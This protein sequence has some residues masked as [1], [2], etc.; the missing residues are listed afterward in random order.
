MGFAS[1]RGAMLPAIDN[2]RP[3][4]Q[5]SSGLKVA[6]AAMLGVGAFG[7]SMPAN[8]YQAS[9]DNMRLS[10]SSLGKTVD[11]DLANADLSLVVDAI[12]RQT[13]ANIVIRSGDHPFGKV[14]VH[15]SNM[16]I[17]RALQ[18]VALSAGASLVKDADGTYILKQGDDSETVAQNQVQ[19]PSALT[20]RSYREADLHWYKMVLQHAVPH[21][22][23]Y[24]L[25][26]DEGVRDIDPFA[27]RLDRSD[28]FPRFDHNPSIVLATGENVPSVPAGLGSMGPAQANRTQDGD[29][30]QQARQFPG[31]FGGG[32]FGGGG[33]GGG[34]GGIGGGIGGVGGGIGGAGGIGGQQQLPEGVDEIIALQADNSLLVKATPEAFQKMREIIK[35]I[36]VAPRQVQIRVE[37]VRADVNDVDA[38]GINYEFVPF[39]GINFASDLGQGGGSYG[40]NFATGNLVGQ[41]LATLT[42]GRAKILN[43]PIITTTNNVQGQIQVNNSIPVTTTTTVVPN[44]GQ[45]VSSQSVQFQNIPT[46]LS[47]T[48][49]INSDDSIT[50]P[51]SLDISTPGASV[52]NSGAVATNEQ[53][54]Q[55]VR[56]VKSGETMVLGGFINDN[57]QSVRTSIPILGDLPLIG[58]L[59]RNRNRTVN[60]SE[61]LI[62]VTPTIIGEDT[63]SSSNNGTGS[64]SVSP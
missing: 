19:A 7:A 41:M 55:T 59:F 26:W 38:F 53:A 23:L 47:V 39:P 45:A 9:A 4:R 36:D 48:P 49:R 46:T 3:N 35:Y 16:Q 20:R 29:P 21:D 2:D 50:L 28:K 56:T 30:S 52:G 12:Q 62:F 24:L 25:H 54:L 44:G 37:F 33:I 57:E 42:H 15:L 1:R 14:N 11:L 10:G 22:V 31:G 32:G 51:L 60:N 17:D 13:G 8:A 58:G 34:R 6:I 27:N 40:L 64:V 18:N 61:L 63:G 43:A 5:V